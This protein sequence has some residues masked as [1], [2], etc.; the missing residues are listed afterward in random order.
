MIGEA[1]RIIGSLNYAKHGKCLWPVDTLLTQSEVERLE[2]EM[3]DYYLCYYPQHKRRQS[4]HAG[5]RVERELYEDW[6]IKHC[7]HGAII[8]I[9]GN[10]NR[11]TRLGRRH[12]NSLMPTMDGRDWSRRAAINRWLAP[13]V[14]WQTWAQ[15]DSTQNHRRLPPV[16]KHGGCSDMNCTRHHVHEYDD[17]KQPECIGGHYQYAISIHSL[18]YIPP[19]ELLE[20]LVDNQIYTLYA[21]IHDFSG[22]QPA[23][24]GGAKWWRVD[25]KDNIIDG[26]TGGQVI[27]DV[28]GETQFGPHGDC[29]WLHGS[30]IISYGGYTLQWCKM[31]QG[32]YSS[33]WK[34]NAI[35][36]HL[37]TRH[38]HA[39]SDEADALLISNK[40]ARDIAFFK[41]NIA[42]DVLRK[43]DTYHS[44][45]Y[46]WNSATALVRKHDLSIS[47]QEMKS[48]LDDMKERGDPLSNIDKNDPKRVQAEYNN[49]LLKGDKVDQ[50]EYVAEYM[51]SVART[52]PHHDQEHAILDEMERMNIVGRDDLMNVAWGKINF[53]LWQSI[54][55]IIV[56]PILFVK[57]GII[58]L[59]GMKLTEKQIHLGRMML[60]KIF[61]YALIF[62]IMMLSGLIYTRSPKCMVILI[63]GLIIVFMVALFIP[64]IETFHEVRWFT[65]R[66]KRR[67]FELLKLWN[68]E[69]WWKVVLKTLDALGLVIMWV[70][71]LLLLII[72]YLH[73]GQTLFLELI[74][75]MVGVMATV[76]GIVLSY[77]KFCQVTGF[78]FKRTLALVVIWLFDQVSAGQSV[79]YVDNFYTNVGYMVILIIIIYKIM[80]CLSHFHYTKLTKKQRKQ[81]DATY[82]RVLKGACYGGLITWAL[83]RAGSSMVVGQFLGEELQSMSCQHHKPMAWQSGPVTAIQPVITSKCTCNSLSTLANRCLREPPLPP[84]L[85]AVAE[86]ADFVFD[87]FELAFPIVPKGPGMEIFDW[88]DTLEGAKKRDMIDACERHWTTNKTKHYR[89]KI[90]RIKAFK[91]KENLIQNETKAARLVSGRS[92]LF[93]VAWGRCIKSLSKVIKQCWSWKPPQY[94]KTYLWTEYRGHVDTFT[95][96]N[97]YTRDEGGDWFRWALGKV[98]PHGIPWTISTDFSKYDVS[99]NEYIHSIQCWLVEQLTLMDD[100]ARWALHETVM[101]RGILSD[102]RGEPWASVAYDVG[103]AKGILKSG[104][105]WTSLINTILTMLLISYQCC[106]SLA[107]TFAQLLM[108]PLYLLGLGD[109]S[110]NVTTYDNAMKITAMDYLS[111]LGIKVK[112]KSGPPEQAEFC[113]SWF[114]PC[115]INGVDSYL[116]TAKPG[117]ILTKSFYSYKKLGD[118]K[119]RGYARA[120]AEG[121]INDYRHIPFMYS[122]LRAILDDC[123]ER[124]IGKWKHWDK[125]WLRGTKYVPEMTD[126]TK[127]WMASVWGI[128]DFNTSY[129][130]DVKKNIFTVLDD[131]FI[132]QICRVDND[133]ELHDFEHGMFEITQN[134]F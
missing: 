54:I 124:G 42:F 31:K 26:E 129:Y 111:P 89:R 46:V 52:I 33:V 47:A 72:A 38:R 64:P 8:D 18:Y 100:D 55:S 7:K 28:I 67:T 116:L 65:A 37:A 115:K 78:N 40:K 66:S 44:I 101:T 51:E 87:N 84:D 9:G 93:N 77:I 104:D 17:S 27:M 3:P 63:I 97:G 53:S 117:R 39:S 105:Q 20:G 134:H 113:S 120:V 43:T 86:F 5:L 130:D 13:E 60:V 61:N 133:M 83:Q 131:D 122:I 56:F 95:Y 29:S 94:D 15:Y 119:A 14:T 16:G 108:E 91:K 127:T 23:Y 58:K 82:R 110:T 21:L 41:K 92:N 10:Q 96:Y 125:P 49:K 4:A 70:T 123:Q 74:I 59:W 88:I 121:F 30:E 85:D 57:I 50:T 36:D 126:E 19:L 45:N 76:V 69:G 25:D 118:R 99:Q 107:I 71:F 73:G 102:S 81:M 24:K 48:I 128:T 12:I 109:D 132:N 34:I 68:D 11:H 114:I 106:K 112:I 62:T 79:T 22:P 6:I 75:T 32:E 2:R 98:M 103:G 1:V 35:P 80:A 90:S